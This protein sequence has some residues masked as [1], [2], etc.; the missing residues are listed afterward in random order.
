MR[1]KHVVGCLLLVA[2]AVV[3]GCN[4]ERNLVGRWDMGRSNFYFRGDGVVFY[5]SSS[6]TRYQG[7]YYYDDS[8]DPAILRTDLAEING[9]GRP[10]SLQ[11]QVSYLGAD[12]LQLVSTSNGQRRSTLAS[13]MPENLNE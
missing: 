8:S 5:L 9:N 10:F 13:R 3:S 7:R 11:F 2:T 12:C 1:A 4:D 6:K